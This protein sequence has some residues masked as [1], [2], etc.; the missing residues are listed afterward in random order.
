MKLFVETFG[1]FDAPEIA[2]ASRSTSGTDSWPTT[3]TT[4]AAESSWTGKQSD[5]S[6]FPVY[7]SCKIYSRLLLLSLTNKFDKEPVL[8]E[9]GSEC[10]MTKSLEIPL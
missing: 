9:M 4:T 6:I 5:Y 8:T 1:Q 3:P 7:S 10:Q 2:T